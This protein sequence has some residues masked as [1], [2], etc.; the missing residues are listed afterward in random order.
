[1]ST[2]LLPRYRE[3]FRLRGLLGRTVPTDRWCLVGG[4]TVLVAGRL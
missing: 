4:L 1:M 2:D 3:V